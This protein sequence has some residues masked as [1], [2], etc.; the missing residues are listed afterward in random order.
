MAC[1]GGTGGGARFGLPLVISSSSLSSFM[2]A[3]ADLIRR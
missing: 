1:G 3:F 2:H